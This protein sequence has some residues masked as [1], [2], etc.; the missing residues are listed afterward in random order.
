MHTVG[1]IDPAEVRGVVV[2]EVRRREGL[3][4]SGPDQ[5]FKAVGTVDDELLGKE[6]GGKEHFPV[7][8]FPELKDEGG[9]E[10]LLFVIEPHIPVFSTLEVGQH[11]ILL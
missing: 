9:E 5:L 1:I 11:E 2:C 10:L 8:F 7:S 3:F 6:G 4:I